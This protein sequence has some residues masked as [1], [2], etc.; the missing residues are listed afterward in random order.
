VSCL[1]AE[2]GGECVGVGALL[3]NDPGNDDVAYVLLCSDGLSCVSGADG[4]SCI[5]RVGAACT[6]GTE[7]TCEGDVL[8]LCLSGDAGR[9]FL[10]DPVGVDCASFGQKCNPNA[11]L[12]DGSRGASCD[13]LACNVSGFAS[14]TLNVDSATFSNDGIDDG[15]ICLTADQRQLFFV[16][17]IVTDGNFANEVSGSDVRI[18]TSRLNGGAQI[19]CSNSPSSTVI[20][21][22]GSLVFCPVCLT[23]GDDLTDLAV[24]VTDNVGSRTPAVCA[25]PE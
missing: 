20:D 1:Q 7:A 18:A 25:V 6:S 15:T 16:S 19:A 4:E 21:G 11:T 14:G 22:V 13:D 9:F 8:R 23:N 2:A 17:V 3:D 10:P 24:Q 12:N 5:A